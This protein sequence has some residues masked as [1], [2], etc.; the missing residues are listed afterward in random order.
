MQ[1]STFEGLSVTYRSDGDGLGDLNATVRVG[2]FSGTSTSLVD[3]DALMQ[4]VDELRK[5]PW[6][7]EAAEV[8]AG[9]G[10]HDTLRLSASSIGTTGRLGVRVRVSQ[11]DTY[12]QS[13]TFGHADEANILVLTTYEAAR[14]FADELALAV[15]AGAGDA[16]LAS[17]SRT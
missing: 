16:H 5:Y 6:P 10:E 17:E 7:Q 9:R 2:H 8:A 12:L 13:P 11:V 15:R 1:E 3:D 14:G 4:W